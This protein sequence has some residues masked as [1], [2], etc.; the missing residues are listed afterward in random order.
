[1]QGRRRRHERP[2]PEQHREQ[3]RGTTKLA[4]ASVT[5]AVAI[6][7]L[8][9][10]LVLLPHLHETDNPAPAFAALAV[11]Y[12]VGAVLL[13]RLDARWVHVVGA[14]VQAFLVAG[15]LWLWSSSAAAG[16]QQFF[17]DH[18]AL[19][20]VITAAQVALF[21]MLVLLAWPRDEEAAGGSTGAPEGGP[22]EQVG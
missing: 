17:L 18:L 16:D 10:F 5:A 14:V 8:A 7:Y 11:L 12:A 2:G 22:P 4:A 6:L 3:A 1:V 9:L 21:A 19:G 13:W 20:V 15:Y